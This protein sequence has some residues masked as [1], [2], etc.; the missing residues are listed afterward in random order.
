MNTKSVCD[1]SHSIILPL[2]LCFCLFCQCVL[3]TSKASCICHQLFHFPNLPTDVV[4]L[5]TSL[6]FF[7]LL[8]LLEA[9]GNHL[10]F[11][12][13]PLFQELKNHE[14]LSVTDNLRNVQYVII[15][16]LQWTAYFWESPRDRRC[17]IT[18]KNLDCDLSL[19]CKRPTSN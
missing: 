1:L 13:F 5:G 9:H 2:F 15:A 11:I 17:L 12:P 4:F 7:W 8:L 14:E 16:T 10:A 3:S 6:A 19:T 18:Q